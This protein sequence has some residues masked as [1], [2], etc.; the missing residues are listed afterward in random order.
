MKRRTLL[1]LLLLATGVPGCYRY[2]P[3]TLDAVPQGA[4]IRAVLSPA[5]SAALMERQGISSGRHLEGTV[6]ED[7]GATLSLWVASV[8]ASRE[9]G[10]GVLY[11]QVDVLKSDVLRVDLR[12]LDRGKTTF[13]A[14][15]GAAAVA[16]VARAALSG[17]TG[18]SN[19]GGGGVPPES[20]R[21]RLPIVILRF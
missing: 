15:G 12:E 17:G 5:A 21:T 14:V 18:E 8:P 20:R 9:F 1:G 3:V 4:T 16:V 19:S 6:L 7:H 13:L 2:E 10:S 11:Q